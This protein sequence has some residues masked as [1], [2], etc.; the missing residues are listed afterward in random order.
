MKTSLFLKLT[1]STIIIGVVS[2]ASQNSKDSWADIFNGRDLSG[3]TIVNDAE[4]KVDNGCIRIIKGMG[5]LRSNK[6]YKNF[7]L[8]LEWRALSDKYDSGIFI[9]ADSAGTPWPTNAWQVNLKYDAIGGLVRGSKVIVPSETPKIPTN[10]W[11]KFRIEVIGSKITLDV[12]NER[13]WEFE[14]LDAQKGYI[15]IQAEDKVFD[16]RN[17]KIRELE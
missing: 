16:F 10:Q 2:L 12:D 9:R 15:G 4:F 8:E 17:I 13:A 11:V 1:I 14:K 5:W 6:E 7:I 3:W